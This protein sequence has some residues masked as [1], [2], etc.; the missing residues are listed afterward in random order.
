MKQKTKFG[1]NAGTQK[2]RTAAAIFAAAFVA[3]G[4]GEFPQCQI[5]YGRAYASAC[6][7]ALE[8]GKEAKVKLQRLNDC[9]ER[10]RKALEKKILGG[11]QYPEG[12]DE[13]NAALRGVRECSAQ[14]S[15]LGEVKQKTEEG[16]VVGEEL[17]GIDVEV[18]KIIS[19]M[20]ELEKV[21]LGIAG[22]K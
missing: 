7:G 21:F 4:C 16:T 18:E 3:A 8:K 2:L 5:N 19:K 9:R 11:K 13:Y 22:Q 15:L 6:K 10:A 14:I 20:E 1:R 17:E 12:I